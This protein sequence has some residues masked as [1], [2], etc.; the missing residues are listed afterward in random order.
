MSGRSE[1]SLASEAARWRKSC[2]E[3]RSALRDANQ[4]LLVIY[5]RER[6][7]DPGDFEVYVD[8][9]RVVDHSGRIVWARVAVLVDEL[10]EVKP[11]LA[12]PDERVSGQ[13][14]GSA[15]Q[16]LATGT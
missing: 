16:W 14:G 11:H 12:A 8:P 1:Q 6:L 15:L 10:L 9:G 2:Q 4:Q 7:A 5:L 3:A 13:R